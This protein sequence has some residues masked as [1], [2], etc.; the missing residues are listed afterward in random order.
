MKTKI[1]GAAKAVQRK[2][3]SFKYPFQKERSQ[4]NN[5]SFYLKKLGEKE[6]SKPKIRRKDIIN[7]RIKIIIVSQ[8]RG[9]VGM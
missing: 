3:Y 5:L 2:I 8:Q 4:T 7:I 9:V 6:Q 1:I